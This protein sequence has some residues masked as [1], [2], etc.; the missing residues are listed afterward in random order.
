ML[1]K[2][3]LIV[4][5]KDSIVKPYSRPWSYSNED[6]LREAIRILE[7]VNCGELNAEV[8]V[9]ETPIVIDEFAKHALE[10]LNEGY[11]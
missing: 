1:L 10:T 8:T 9:E 6:N 2:E 4:L 5:M 11:R 7:G 3:H